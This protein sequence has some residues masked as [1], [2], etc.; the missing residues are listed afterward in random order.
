MCHPVVCGIGHATQHPTTWDTPSV[1]MA[2]VYGL[3]TG[4]VVLESGTLMATGNPVLHC[5]RMDDP[6]DGATILWMSSLTCYWSSP[7]LHHA[8]TVVVYG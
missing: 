7:P 6:M 5:L 8:P 1:V 4:Y 3:A 2:V